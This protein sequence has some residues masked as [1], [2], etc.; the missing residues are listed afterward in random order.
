MKKYIL[1]IIVLVMVVHYSRAQESLYKNKVRPIVKA[2]IDSMYPQAVV[3]DLLKSDSIQTMQINCYCSET[4]GMIILTFDTNGNLLRK[5]IHYGSLKG[6]PDTIMNY[7]QKNKSS[8]MEFLNEMRKIVN[9]KGETYYE[10]IVNE[11]PNDWTVESYILKFKS[12]GEL[13]SKKALPH[14][15]R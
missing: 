15:E 5:E 12:T 3:T 4:N 13:I 9:N 1:G 2:K 6:L 7:I 14:Y 10:I 8:Q 11:S